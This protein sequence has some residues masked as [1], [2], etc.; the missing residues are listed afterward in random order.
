MSEK[1][2]KTMTGKLLKRIET[3]ETLRGE[4]VQD[5]KTLRSEAISK[6]DQTGR[7]AVELERRVGVF[8]AQ[9]DSVMP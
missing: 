7:A 8:E 2:Q 3:C 9:L 4:A 5:L 1:L 6:H